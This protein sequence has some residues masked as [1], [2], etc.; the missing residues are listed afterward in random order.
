MAIWWRTDDKLGHLITSRSSL[1]VF[2][3]ID[4]L[5]GWLTCGVT[6]LSSERVSGTVSESV[7]ER[8]RM[9]DYTDGEWE[10]AREKEWLSEKE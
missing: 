9:S 2:L 6:D 3:R 8:E 10:W 4:P 7:S 1:S 5:I